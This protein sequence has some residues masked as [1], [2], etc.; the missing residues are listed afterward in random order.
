MPFNYDDGNREDADVIT[1]AS[2]T[3]KKDKENGERVSTK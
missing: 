1:K 3:E 2:G